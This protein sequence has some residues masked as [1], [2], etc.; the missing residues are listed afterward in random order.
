MRCARTARM[1][2]AARSAAARWP[3][4]S[5]SSVPGGCGNAV[6]SAGTGSPPTCWCCRPGCSTAGW[7]R[8]SAQAIVDATERGGVRRTAPARPGRP[9][10]R[11]AGRDGPGAPGATRAW[12]SPTSGRRAA[13]GWHRTCRWSGCGWRADLVE[14]QVRVEQ[15]STE[16]L[17][18][19][20]SQ[21][22]RANVYQPLSFRPVADLRD[23]APRLA[24]CFPGDDPDPL[25]D[26][27]RAGDPGGLRRVSRRRCV[28]CW[29]AGR[30]GS[31][32]RRWTP[33]CN[34]CC[35]WN[36]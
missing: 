35:G 24:L 17:T 9:G 14:V 36:D 4:R 11:G 27:A 19:Q 1:T 12:R 13:D 30:S 5:S 23:P 20:A 8:P 15:T 29:P 34:C 33:I 25:D 6:T 18:C 3:P 7:S 16:W 32:A 31:T 22:S 2:C 26:R 10:A 21:P 28:G